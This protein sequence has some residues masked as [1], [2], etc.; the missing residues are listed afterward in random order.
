VTT[1]AETQQTTTGQQL[2]RNATLANFTRTAVQHSTKESH[3]AAF[4]AD[5]VNEAV[6]VDRGAASLPKLPLNKTAQ[7]AVTAAM[8]MIFQ[9]KPE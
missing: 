4:H 9:E 5:V 7:Q 2:P 3:H 1:A 8:I 6:I